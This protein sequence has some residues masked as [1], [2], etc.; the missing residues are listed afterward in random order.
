MDGW[1]ITKPGRANIAFHH[2]HTAES[3]MKRLGY[4]TIRGFKYVEKP[5]VRSDEDWRDEHGF[6]KCHAVCC[7]CGDDQRIGI[8]PRFGYPICEKHKDMKPTEVLADRK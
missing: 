5:M 1:V 6:Y 2:K 3:E 4:K 8:E 7:V